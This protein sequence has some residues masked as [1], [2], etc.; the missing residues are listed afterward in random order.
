MDDRPARA[1][2]IA[3]IS[4]FL[5]PIITSITRFAAARSGSTMAFISARGV[6]CQDSPNLSLH[7][8]H[9]DS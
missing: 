8:P 2:S 9:C 5:M 3:A 7:Q 1:C 4:I 6:I